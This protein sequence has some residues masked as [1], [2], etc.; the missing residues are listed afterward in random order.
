MSPGNGTEM[1]EP[2][3]PPPRNVALD[4]LRA[5]AMLLGLV[6]HGVS[7]FKATEFTRY[8]IRDRHTTVLADACYFTVHDFRMQLFFLLA[9]FAAC[10]LAARR[11]V[12][13]LARNR[14]LR[15]ALPLLVAVA[16]VA[17]VMHVLFVAHEIDRT[18]TRYGAGWGWFTGPEVVL[19]DGTVC[20]LAVL[21]ATDLPDWLG[22]N[23]HLWFL[24]YLA[25]C[26]V[27]LIGWLS[28]GP[29]VAPAGLVRAADAAFRR[30]LGTWWKAPLLAALGVP[31][32]WRMPDWWIDTPRG[33]TPD[34]AIYLY[35]LGFFLFGGM[36][37][38][39]RDRLAEFGRHWKALLLVA[40][41][42]VLPPMLKLT[43][44]GNWAEDAVAPHA[45]PWLLGWKAAAI[46][47]GGLYTWM[48]VEGLVGLFQ[49]H[50]AGSRAWW[51]YLAESSYWCYL[52]GL[53]VQV[54]LQ[55]W[56][57][58]ADLPIAAKF[59]L[60]NALTF[61]ALLASYELCVRHTWVGLMLNGKRPERKPEPPA[62]P[63][64]VSARV[65]VGAPERTRR[66]P[67]PAEVGHK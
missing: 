20:S 43:V 51:K 59:L 11:G 45:P 36:L 57:A 38:R 65:R 63:V 58:G 61:A 12:G 49:R 7:P 19:R 34:G 60:V 44:S 27:P 35:Y 29:R 48:M 2:T 55:V 54:A 33:W 6:A 67:E 40:N 52:A 42:L 16:V 50:F 56:L 9:G 8:A 25:L 10:A 24:Y 17:P 31:V 5:V 26:C 28:A 53:P 41:V 47:L 37:Y 18:A 13:G 14:L 1:A 32:L 4:N 46:F 23:F 3:P 64:V 39:H 15:I 62:E 66:R 30:L 22:P 21:P